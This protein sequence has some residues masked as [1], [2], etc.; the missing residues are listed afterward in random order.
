[1]VLIIKELQSDLFSGLCFIIGTQGVCNP[2]FFSAHFCER[3]H[4]QTQQCPVQAHWEG[5]G[6]PK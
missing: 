2:S 6:L 3:Q 5:N 4:K 1:M